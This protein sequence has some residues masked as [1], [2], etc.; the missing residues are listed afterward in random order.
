MEI[1]PQSR[2]LF[3]SS[4]RP[5]SA[6][7]CYG[8]LTGRIIIFTCRFPANEKLFFLRKLCVFAVKVKIQKFKKLSQ[9]QDYYIFYSF[10][11]VMNYG[12]MIVGPV[13]VLIT[14]ESEPS[15]RLIYKSKLLSSRY[16]RNRSRLKDDSPTSR[17]AATHI[18]AYSSS[19]SL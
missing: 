12:V 3:F 8:G 15:S 17:A 5:S 2:L 4:C 16:M 7:A 13:L 14:P 19:S 1:S 10:W 11:T 9:L 6:V 18:L